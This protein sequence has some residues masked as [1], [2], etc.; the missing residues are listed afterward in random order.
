[1]ELIQIILYPCI[2]YSLVLSFYLYNRKVHPSC[3]WLAGLILVGTLEMINFSVQEILQEMLEFRSTGIP[4]TF[5]LPPFIYMYAR[6]YITSETRITRKQ[7][8]LFIPFA[9]VFLFIIIKTLY[10]N[11]F[12]YELRDYYWNPFENIYFHIEA[13]IRKGLVITFCLATIYRSYSFI[14][15]SKEAS[16]SDSR[17][18]MLTI[19]WL[20]LGS[21]IGTLVWLGYF[22]RELWYFPNPLPLISYG[23]VY[24]LLLIVLHS[25]G[26][27]SA[28][29]LPIYEKIKEKYGSQPLNQD[30]LESIAASIRFEIESNNLHLNPRLSLEVLSQKTGIPSHKISQTFTRQMGTSFLDYINQMRIL[31]FDKRLDSGEDKVYNLLSIALSCGFNSKATFNRVFKKFK[32]VTPSTYVKKRKQNST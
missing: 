2:I 18:N 25:T 17:P 32:G 10:I 16:V 23:P 7:K 20:I 27:L 8:L 31:E 21:L 30:S 4:A 9:I 29:K 6:I 12:K 15:N 1:M 28:I 19:N 26:F 14:R 13:M 24:V 22:I 5:L 3:K 11:L